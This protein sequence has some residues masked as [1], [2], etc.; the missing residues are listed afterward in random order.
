[1]KRLELPDVTLVMLETQ[2]HELARLAV[3]ECL[4]KVQFGDA[5]IFTDDETKF[6]ALGNK[7]FNGQGCTVKVPNWPTKLGWSQASWYDVP[8][9]LRTSHALFIQWD[10]WVWDLEKWNDEFLRYDYI[11]GTKTVRTSATAA[12]RSGQRR[13][14]V[15]CCDGAIKFLA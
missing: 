4:D 3:E 2:E 14:V 13:S 10:S 1:M 7:F 15:T 9:L 5:L 8:P 6:Y 11:G 12:S